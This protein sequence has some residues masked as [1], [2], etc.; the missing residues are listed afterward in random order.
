MD[1]I[2]GSYRC[3]FECCTLFM[4]ERGG[5]YTAANTNQ[6]QPYG[7]VFHRCRLTG[8]CQPGEGWLGRPWRKYARTVFL[9]CEMDEHV[10]PEG[11]CDWDKDRVVTD[12]YGEWH[13]TG[14]RADQTVRHPSQ[15]R[16]TD[17]EALNITLSQV[18]SG[19][20]DWQPEDTVYRDLT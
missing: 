20:D 17:E 19:S 13:T 18:M 11:F 3:W 2:F 7:F 9:E 8:D 14:V 12:R 1:F 6:A 16:L 5:Y 10:A 15:K 4:N